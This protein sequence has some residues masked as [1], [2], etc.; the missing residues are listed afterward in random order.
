LLIP[1]VLAS[2][3]VDRY[4]LWINTPD[5]ADIAFLEAMAGIDDRIRLVRPPEGV[6]PGPAAI[7]AFWPGAADADAVYVR[8]DDDVVW[9]DP[10][11][12]DT[13][14]AFRLA[15]PEYFAVAPLVINNAMGSYLLQTFRKIRTSRPVGPDRFDPVGWVNPTLARALHG[16]LQELVAAGEVGKLD[17]GRIPL[18]GN[19]F[20]INCI[21][22]FGRDF[23]SFGGVVPKGD[24]EEAAASCTLALRMGRVNAVETGAVAAHFAFYTQ[25]DLM[26][27]TDLLAGYARLATARPEIEPWRTRVEAIY[28]KLEER[29]P[30]HLSLG[31][32]TPWVG[33]KRSLVKRLLRPKRDPEEITVERGAGF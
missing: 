25:R 11:F 20:S 5:E 8:F 33:R 2:P 1:Y 13:L 29:F 19:C 14:L 27:R 12:F 32:F 30:I 3:H 23:A 16:F 7:A 21:A 9:V 6:T 26:D 10:R 18:S 31:G 17:C 24:D 22:W 28:G 4:D 15:H